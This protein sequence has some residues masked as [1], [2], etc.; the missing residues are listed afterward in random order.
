LFDLLKEL[1]CVIPNC[2]YYKRGDFELKK[3]CK[4]AGDRGFTDLMV[5]GEKSKK[6]NALMVV[7]LPGKA[8]LPA[9]RYVA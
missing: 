1:V 9:R 3:I 6:T 8:L 4:W 5:F 7:H 2:S